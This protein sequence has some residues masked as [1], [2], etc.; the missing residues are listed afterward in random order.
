MVAL[1]PKEDMTRAPVPTDLDPVA[2]QDILRVLYKLQVTTPIT[3]PMTV[4]TVNPNT[5]QTAVDG[6]LTTGVVGGTALDFFR[7]A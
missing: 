2:A 7:L 1:T 6:L 3:R 4:G 5:N